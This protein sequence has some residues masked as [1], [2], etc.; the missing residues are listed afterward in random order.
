MAAVLRQ[1]VFLVID[2]FSCLRVSD[3]LAVIVFF[4]IYHAHFRVPL[5]CL[6]VKI[7]TTDALNQGLALPLRFTRVFSCPFIDSSS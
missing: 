1:L 3:R 7:V 5:S 4:L 6:L 2:H